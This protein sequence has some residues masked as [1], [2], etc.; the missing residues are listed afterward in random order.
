MSSYAVNV[1]L[2]ANGSHNP[3]KLGC[4]T[5]G[6]GPVQGSERFED[7]ARD[8]CAMWDR[9]NP[10]SA[11]WLGIHDYDD[12][13]GDFSEAGF[14]EQAGEMLE[15]E[16]R[17]TQ[18]DPAT[19]GA[20]E[21]I[22][23]AILLADIRANRWSIEKVADWRRNPALYVQTPLMGLL[24]LVSRETI[25]LPDRLRSIIGRLTEL[26]DVLEAGR[27]NVEEPPRVFTD[28]AMQATHAGM[29][30]VRSTLPSLA[31]REP[32]MEDELLEA[33]DDAEAALESHLHYLRAELL[34]ESSGDFAVGR[35]LFDER[36]REWHMLD[37]DADGLRKVGQTM[38][39]E[40]RAAIVKVAKEIDAKTDWATQ[41]EQAKRDHPSAAQLMAAYQQEIDRLRK[42]IN[43]QGLVTIPQGERLALVE[44]PSFE[45]SIVPYAAYMPPGPFEAD[46]TGQF[47][48]TPVNRETSPRE[49]ETQLQEHC[50]PHLPLTTLHEGY[51]GHH[52]QLCVANR[53]GSV[54]R[55]RASS[56]LFAE[57]WALYCE[58]MM[59]EQG[60]FTDPRTRLFQLKDMLWRAARVVIDAGLHT[61]EMTMGEAVDLLVNEAKLARQQAEGEVRRYTMSPTQPM[62][63]AMGKH[64][65]LELRKEHSKLSLRDFHD[66]LL[67]H[68]T[69]P[70][71]LV[72]RA[73]SA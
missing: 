53:L 55:R 20:S 11:S 30:F 3:V 71:A 65:I 5:G 39:E 56:D 67:S 54:M 52:L 41:L 69:I 34:P 26:R 60:Y 6:T 14:E 48:V 25:P 47:W 49:Q 24:A 1:A 62:T 37:V 27:D 16:N 13:L 12:R 57:G 51:P 17:L 73:M 38:L 22:D 23:Y 59:G 66:R 42:F 31:R 18:I 44:T 19:L 7:L 40:T 64:A 33:L 35:E 10:V 2:V 15:Y 50:L 72:R 45:R 68:G 36:L 58:Q 46:Q 70:L 43:E 4:S 9:L 32:D 63:Y 8:Y 21:Q 28:V 61:G 29:G